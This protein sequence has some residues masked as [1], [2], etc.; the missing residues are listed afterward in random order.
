MRWTVA[1]TAAATTVAYQATFSFNQREIYIYSFS[2]CFVFPSFLP[3]RGGGEQT[4]SLTRPP[5]NDAATKSA[6][7]GYYL[8]PQHSQRS[9]FPP[10]RLHAAT[11]TA[12]GN[13]QRARIYRPV[14]SRSLAYSLV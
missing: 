7:A 6:R 5:R 11:D 3:K 14:Y 1:T 2:F 4:H 10:V 9:T 12:V 13:K 8:N